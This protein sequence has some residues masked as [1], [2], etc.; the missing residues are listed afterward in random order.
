M[1]N[2]AC[3]W[4]KKSQIFLS[5]LIY[6]TCW[7]LDSLY[8]VYNVSTIVLT[9]SQTSQYHRDNLLYSVELSYTVSQEMYV[10][11]EFIPNCYQI[12]VSQTSQYHRDNL[13]YSVELSYTVSQEM[14]VNT[15]FIPNCY[16]I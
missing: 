8:N 10:N 16:Q 7:L 4:F 12:Y 6:N 1:L 9:V 2:I 14:Y 5:I 3:I 15:E 13:L 11:T